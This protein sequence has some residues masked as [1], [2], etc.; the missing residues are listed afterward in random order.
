MWY[1]SSREAVQMPRAE[2]AILAAATALFAAA[3][4][5]R[6]R[7]RLAVAG[8]SS[9]PYLIGIADEIAK[10]ALQSGRGRYRTMGLDEVQRKLGGDALDRLAG[11][12]GKVDCEARILS[13]LGVD[14]ALTGSLAQTETAYEVHLRL[15]DVPAAR[16][17]ASLD[18]TV[19]IASRRLE[20]DLSEAL[21]RLLSG[22]A[23][24]NGTIAARPSPANAT[25]ELDG[26]PVGIGELD[27]SVA[28]GKHRLVFR[29]PGYLDTERWVTVAPGQTLEVAERL[30]PTSGH[31]EA[32]PPPEAKRAP[33]AAPEAGAGGGVPAATIVAAAVAAGLFGGGLYL[34]LQSNALDHRAGQFDLNQV[35]QGLTRAQA[36]TAVQD[37][38]VANYLFIGSAAALAVAVIVAVLAPGGSAPGTPAYGAPAPAATWSL[39]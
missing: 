28:P 34:G 6:E 21:P 38:R 1:S 14:R 16:L 36:L 32:E 29:A 11:C 27:R 17:V 2:A 24:A 25:V 23:E 8:P 10:L 3:A 13:P 12:D 20:A 30:V 22:E 39:P 5:A 19:L 7:P 33:A 26:A 18:R 4:A 9:P 15:L 35:D 31:V 37:A